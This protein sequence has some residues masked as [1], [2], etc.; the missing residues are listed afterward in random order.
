[1][2]IAFVI[3][4]STAAAAAQSAR[5]S[6][7][8]SGPA[9]EAVQKLPSM[10][11]LTLSWEQR[12][13]P[14]RALARAHPGNWP[15]QILLQD[16]IHQRFYMGQEWDQTIDLY[17][18]MEDRALG[19]LLEARLLSGLHRK[20]SRELLDR[21]LQTAPDSPW[22]HLAMLEWAAHP[23]YRDA[24]LAA[25]HFEEFRRLCPSEP[26]AFAFLDSVQDASKMGMHVRVLRKLLE[27]KKKSG[28]TDADLGLF[29]PAWTWEKIVAGDAGSGQFL[30]VV[31]ADLAALRERPFYGA[32]VW[33]ATVRFG[34]EHVLKDTSGLESLHEQ[35]LREAPQ[36]LT[37]WLVETERSRK[38]NSPP[39]SPS[40]RE[41]MEVWQAKMETGIRD[42]ISRFGYQPFLRFDLQQLLLN[43]RTKLSAEEFGKI[44]DT[45]LTM[46][47]QYPDQSMSWPP[48]QILIA[49]QYANR[50]IRLSQV[51]SLVDQG[52]QQIEFQE[53]YR[54]DSDAIPK[55]AGMMDNITS[56]QQR[57]REILIRHAIATEQ[58]ERARVMLADFRRMLEQTKP[59][60]AAGQA[61][62]MWRRSHSVY[63]ELAKSAGVDA[64]P[65]VEVLPPDPARAGRFPVADFE[66]KDLSGRT[67]KL[68]DLKGKVAY[69]N[70]W[71]TW[72]GPCRAEMPGIQR[73]HERW[74]E[75]TDRVVLTIS[76]DMHPTLP[77]DYVQENK[78]TF[79]VV[80]GREIAEKFFPPVYFP[81]N[82][83][84]DPEGRRLDLRA[85]NAYETTLQQ[86]EDLAAKLL[87]PSK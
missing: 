16:P 70:V 81:Q 74:K 69:V 71:T 49:E 61:A 1:M 43:P 46:N 58:A 25:K 34:Y 39:Q 4:I 64:H 11:D 8:I 53:K 44:A 22:V 28:L 32:P 56:A 15:L 57:T 27:A 13:A 42:R 73:L 26:R 80:Y 65:V 63:L 47:E 29:R 7:V 52:L 86:I 50:R 54:R 79:P 37:A 9:A 48:A 36:S 30:E 10:S 21:A 40:S 62:G 85:P 5:T 24:P 19:D 51:P 3:V 77:R 20:R 45:V 23:A 60:D 76:A 31:R 66:A 83:M 72:C 35:V 55:V 14:R 2:R 18:R 59:P 82:W 67:W 75:R 87:P 12:L 33:Y 68:S 6:C 78:Y 38:E 41:A 84:I 17:R